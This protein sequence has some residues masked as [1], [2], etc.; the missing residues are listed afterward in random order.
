MR[1]KLRS[2]WY[3]QTTDLSVNMNAAGVYQWSIEGVGLYVGKAKVLRERLRDYP[4]NVRGMLEGRF[5]HGDPLKKY[6]DIHRALRAA[7]DNETPV[8]VTVLENCDP[9]IRSEREQYWIRLRRAEADQG[10]P[11]V[12]NSNRTLP[13][14]R[15]GRRTPTNHEFADL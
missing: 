10:G 6:R 12:I 11:P 1:Q 13:T 7:Y 5:W 9:T 15:H 2:D 14:A 4:R 8:F 3:Q